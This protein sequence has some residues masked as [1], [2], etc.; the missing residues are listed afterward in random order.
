MIIAN[1]YMRGSF[2]SRVF[3]FRRSCLS[4]VH[5]NGAMSARVASALINLYPVYFRIIESIDAREIC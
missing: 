3:K 4:R 5:M 1:G 2:T